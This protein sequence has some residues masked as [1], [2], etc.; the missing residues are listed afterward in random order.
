MQSVQPKASDTPPDCDP[1]DPP[2][3]DTTAEDHPEPN[4]PGADA[5]LRPIRQNRN[6][7]VDFRN[8]KRSNVTHASTADPDARLC[9][10]SPGTGATLCFIGHVLMANALVSLIVKDDITQADG[11]AG[12]RSAP[13]MIHRNSPGSTQRPTLGA[14]KGHDAAGF[15]ADLRQACVPPRHAEI[16]IL[17]DQRQNHPARGLYRVHQAPQA[18]RGGLRLDQD[19]RWHGT[20]RLSRR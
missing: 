11:H 16:S 13:D 8:E 1:G 5:V 12:R 3:P 19:R 14:D 9:K 2:G 20:D 6:A 18:D 7:E 17:R 15:F 10:T 4:E